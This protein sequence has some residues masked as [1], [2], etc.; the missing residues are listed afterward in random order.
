MDEHMRRLFP[1]EEDTDSGGARDL[2]DWGM[3]AFLS[4]VGPQ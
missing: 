1:D 2:S 3:E 4:R